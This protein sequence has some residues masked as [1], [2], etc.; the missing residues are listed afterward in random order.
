MITF[1]GRNFD[2]P[3]VML[4]SAIH[5]IKPPLNL[6]SGTKFNYFG[7]IDLIDELSFYS[8]GSMGATKKFNFDF[9]TQAFGIT[10]PKEQGVDGSLV[11]EFF[12]K[13]QIKEIAEYCMR[14]VNA[15]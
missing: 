10:S 7:H 5:K 12:K 3:F 1:N 2:A 11:P 15:T 13:G 8:T 6:M 14:D 4:R 9:Y